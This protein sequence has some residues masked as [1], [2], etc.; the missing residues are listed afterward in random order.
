MTAASECRGGTLSPTAAN[1]E[2]PLTVLVVDDLPQNVRLL[3]AVL[4]PRG[5][6]VIEA[7]SGE[8]AIAM[9][10]THDATVDLLLLDVQMPGIDG[11]EVCRRLRAD[12][13]TA[14]LPIVMI[15][16]SG[17]QQRISALEAGADDFVAKPFDTA[18]LLARVR[19]LVRIKR[20]HDTVERQAGELAAWNRELEHRVDEQITELERMGRL[21]RFLA[22]QVAELVRSG[23]ESALRSH[24]REIVVLFCDLCGFTSFAESSEPEEVMGVLG[25][26][27]EALGEL[28][29]R[30]EGTLER[31]TGDGL[32][33]FFNDPL[34]C[35]EPALRAVRMALDMRQRV[36]KLET[37][38]SK[39]GHDLG[40]SIGLAQGYATLGRVGY[41][42]RFDYAAI[43]TVTNLAA[44][45]C[46]EAGPWQVLTHERVVAAL[47][48]T[49]DAGLVD[50]LALK[51]LN[52]P[53]RA[54]E[55]NSL[56]TAEGTA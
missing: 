54:F 16:A 24:R 25:E 15:T 55:I 18:E 21:R 49:I 26:Y 35:D 36:R 37:G 43:G 47:G 34:P 40:F 20:F 6:H 12:P 45:L 28:I 4:T 3:G 56:V 22:P 11:Y 19:S 46:G 9:L 32:M 23:D 5:Y 31:F 7:K 33:V 53:V 39:D 1:C 41:A 42:G 48:T 52:R 51:G 30:Y 8:E 44:R 50:T 13:R 2:A 17:D 10:T 29:H 38:W 14:Y 27:H